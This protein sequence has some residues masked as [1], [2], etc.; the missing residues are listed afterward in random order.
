MFLLKKII[1]GFFLPLPVVSILFVVG[2]G[3]LWFSR[4]QKAGKICVSVAL[5]VLVL[6]S[7]EFVANTIL[8]PL[9]NSFSPYLTQ[10]K[11]PV[12]FIE[13]LGGGHTTNKR[14]PSSSQI[15]KESLCRLVEGVALHYKNPGSRIILT[16]YGG[17]DPTPTAIMMYSVAR[18]LGVADSAI[19]VKPQPRDTYEEVLCVKS[20]VGDSS[21]ILVTSASHMRRAMGLFRKQKL[22]PIPAPTYFQAKNQ[23]PLFSR[24][25]ASAL[26]K[27]ETA[28]HE[29]IGL[30]WYG[31]LG[32]L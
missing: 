3:L 22:D 15:G 29:Y 26:E 24:P 32:R 17:I 9:E 21:L 25:S 2:I 4:R 30:V 23:G 1:A 19:I 10:R 5:G 20:I 18:S 27:M 7:N 28:M 16:G 11:E 6:S 14:L 31:L 8:A 13:V 12:R